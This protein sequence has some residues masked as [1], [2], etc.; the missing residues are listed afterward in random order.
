MK[1]ISVGDLLGHEAIIASSAKKPSSYA[2]SAIAFNACE[3]EQ[4]TTVLLS[5][6]P[7]AYELIVTQN[8][9]HMLNRM[10]IFF[11]QNVPSMAQSY[12]GVYLAN[13]NYLLTT[14]TYSQK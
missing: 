3:F 6:C 9:A 10:T 13:R 1:K 2:N 11:R 7:E 5:L 4:H 12:T 14:E 8:A